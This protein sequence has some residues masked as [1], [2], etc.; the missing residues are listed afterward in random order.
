MKG[1]PIM[2]STRPHVNL[3]TPN[4]ITD[5]LS[6]LDRTLPR[7]T[8]LNGVIGILLDG[9]LSRGYGDELSEIDVVVYLDKEHYTAYQN[10]VCPIGLG[11][12]V[13]DGFLYDIKLADY[14]AEAQK[15]WDSVGLWDL[16][17]S[18]IIYDPEGKMAA[19]MEEKLAKPVNPA[20]ACG[21]LWDA[22]WYYQLAGNIWIH[23]QDALQGHYIFN[24]AMK[25]LISALF[26]VN[27]EYIPHDKWL[28]HMSRSLP[29]KPDNWE[30]LLTGAMSMGDCSV[31]SLIDR[32]KCIETLWKSID[33]KL[34]EVLDFHTGLDSTQK[35]SYQTLLKM[36][37][38]EEY[39]IGE[40]KAQM[41]LDALNYEPMHSLFRKEGDK[42]YFLRN[43]LLSLKPED[44]YSWMYEIADEVR[45]RIDY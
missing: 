36:T 23:R 9:G 33:A 35:W 1:F 43:R 8:S 5:L 20:D 19:L 2:I 28:I 29:W 17:Y 7:F 4:K 30:S 44:M 22:C 11:I 40:W 27:G 24:N 42:I 37:A 26:L 39:T 15:A 13:I 21:L 38:K 41:G 12:I 32:Q 31:Q 25:P 45:K 18:K 14:E 3:Q 16:S 34:C 10:G 6:A